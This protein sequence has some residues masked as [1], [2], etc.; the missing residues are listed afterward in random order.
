[1]LLIWDTSSGT[2]CNQ[3]DA[4]LDHNLCRTFR[5]ALN[6]QAT[7]EDTTYTYNPVGQV[8]VQRQCLAAADSTSPTPCPQS[9]AANVTSRDTTRAYTAQYV[10]AGAAPVVYA[11]GLSGGGAVS[12][13]TPTSAT[14]WDA[15]MLYA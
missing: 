15:A 1:T 8:L 11:D 2:A 4:A 12:T 7:A 14:R 10:E 3:P 5:E 13:P 9:T 6:G